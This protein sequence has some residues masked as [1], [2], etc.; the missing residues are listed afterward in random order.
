M[1]CCCFGVIGASGQTSPSRRQAV[2]HFADVKRSGSVAVQELD[3]LILVDDAARFAE[4]ARRLDVGGKDPRRCGRRYPAGRLRSRPATRCGARHGCR[5]RPRTSREAP[6]DH[7]I[8]SGEARIAN[9]TRAR[10]LRQHGRHCARESEATDQPL[11]LGF[12]FLRGRCPI[13]HC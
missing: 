2:A 12:C 3:R 13:G 5:R 8:S 7:G 6:G 9:P 1:S 10:A 4:Q 11:S